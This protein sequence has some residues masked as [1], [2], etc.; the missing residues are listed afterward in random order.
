MKDGS[1]NSYHVEYVKNGDIFDNI[2]SSK[3]PYTNM[4][5]KEVKELYLKE[6]NE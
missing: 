5:A 6:Q 1:I 2:I 4:S 3:L